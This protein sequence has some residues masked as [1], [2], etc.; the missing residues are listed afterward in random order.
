MQVLSGETKRGEKIRIVIGFNKCLQ[1]SLDWTTQSDTGAAITQGFA[2]SVV[3]LVRAETIPRGRNMEKQLLQFQG[4]KALTRIGTASVGGRNSRGS[5][6][7][8]FTAKKKRPGCFAAGGVAQEP[9]VKTCWKQPLNLSP[10]SSNIS[11]NTLINAGR[12]P[13]A[14]EPGRN[15]SRASHV[16][17]RGN[18]RRAPDCRNSWWPGSNKAALGSPTQLSTSANSH[19]MN[20]AVTLV[21]SQPCHFVSARTHSAS[22]SLKI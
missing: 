3:F 12:R 18:I 6:P 10:C 9:G 22:F 20:F 4:K 8:T 1:E 7:L 19:P 17:L 11:H 5:G 16:L 15:L 2:I 14:A 13:F 21:N